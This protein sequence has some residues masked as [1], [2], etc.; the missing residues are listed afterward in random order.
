MLILVPP[1]ES[2]R[3]PLESGPPVDFAALSFPELTPTRR[4]IAEALI[5]TSRRADAFDRL[6]VRPTMAH[7][8]A[9]NTWLLELPAMPVLDVYTG[10][11]HVGLDARRLSQDADDRAQRSLVVLSALWGALRPSDRIPPY[12]L[13]LWADLVGID[14]LDTTWRAVLPAVLRDAAGAGI[15]LDLRSPEFQQ[16]GRPRG[17]ADRTVVIRAITGVRGAHIGD[18]I[19]KRTRGEV[20]RHLLESGAEP[21]ELAEL[22]EIIDT[23]WPV[24]IDPPELPGRPWTMTLTVD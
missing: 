24:A 1:S 4:R 18:V 15:V 19:A 14:R 22:A 21:A 8:V 2:K 12:R 7:V 10:P 11:L 5:E 3:P 17:L 13:R 16:A 6:H 9:Q 20:A 23:R